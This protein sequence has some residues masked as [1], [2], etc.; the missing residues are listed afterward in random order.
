MTVSAEIAFSILIFIELP[1]SFRIALY[2]FQYVRIRAIFYLFDVDNIIIHFILALLFKIPV[3]APL[4][5]FKIEIKFNDR[6][7]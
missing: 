4:C 7:S 3:Y 5:I 2:I 6:F 1:D